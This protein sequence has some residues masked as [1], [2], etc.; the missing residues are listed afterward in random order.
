MCV[1][2]R[3]GQIEYANCTPIFAALQKNFDC[4]AYRF[5]K[6]VPSRLNRMLSVG[7]ID[8]S[9]SSSIQYA[10]SYT[11]YLLLPDLSISS[12]GPVKSVSL[13]SSQP[14]ENLD[15]ECI[16]YS[17]ESE[18]S[19]VL[20]KIILRKYYGY[21]NNFR[22]LEIAE[23]S[24]AFEACPAV[25]LIGDTAI[26]YASDFPGI[27]RYDLGELWHTLSG[28][29][30]V[31]ALWIIREET[32]RVNIKEVKLLHGQLKAAKRIA[33]SLFEVLAYECAKVCNFD[34][35]WLIN[36]WKTISYDLSSRHLEGVKFFY[37]CA[38]EVG[39]LTSEPE[40][41][42]FATPEGDQ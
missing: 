15:G 20:L 24:G 11:K 31:F 32:A 14:I 1:T 8:L 19:I 4:N 33:E 38:Q 41:R 5:V 18:T 42:F 12:D 6:G 17:S 21:S 29:P 9:P 30:F 10:K 28:L 25:L 26:K 7:E 39:V 2:L 35:E 22:A 34:R 27:Y 37:R 23:L 3:I 16:G 13:F 40:I 36:Y